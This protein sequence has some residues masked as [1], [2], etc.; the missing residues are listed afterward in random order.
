[1]VLVQNR[2]NCGATRGNSG[3]VY[4]DTVRIAHPS[5]PEN[6]I[7]GSYRDRR[8]AGRPCWISFT[9]DEISC[10]SGFR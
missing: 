4:P 6:E 2:A 8:H 5:C 1:M 9:F 10:A 7:R 3:D